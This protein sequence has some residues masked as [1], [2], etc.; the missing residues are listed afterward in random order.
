MPLGI[1]RTSR[2][3]SR[4]ASSASAVDGRDHQPRPAQDAPGE[5]GHAA[6]ELD[7]R[8]PHL[9]DERLAR[10]QRD[11]SGGEPVRV[12]E[13]G[14]LGSAPG[15]AREAAEHQGKRSAS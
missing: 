7:V 14:V 10:R 13:I 3:P 12:D 1:V 11:R 9:H 5:R 6:R 2:A 8:P 15:G 4:R